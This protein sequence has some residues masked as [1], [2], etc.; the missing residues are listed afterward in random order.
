MELNASTGK[1]AI[2]PTNFDVKLGRG[3][4]KEAFL[5]HK[6]RLNA[7]IKSW[8]DRL[9]EVAEI[10][11]WNIQPNSE[12]IELALKVVLH[13]PRGN[14]RPL[15]GKLVSWEEAQTSGV[16][17]GSVGR[18]ITSWQKGKLL[19]NGSYGRVYEILTDDGT[20]FAV[21]EVYLLDQGCQSLLYL[22]QE[23]SLLSQLRH[24]N[25]VRYYGTEKDDEK[26][27]LFLEL[28]TKGSLAMLYGKYDLSD[29]QVSALSTLAFPSLP[30]I[31]DLLYSDH[32]PKWLS[33]ML[34]LVTFDTND[35]LPI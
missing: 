4:L 25:I 21:K 33:P 14:E 34:D 16:D 17:N 11:E 10:K 12:A 18:R 5:E 3:L 35:Y 28:M 30:S 19:G 2:L 26:I 20:F 7:D 15:D 29:S 13:K 6:R 8:K 22:E 23:I 24:D 1:P 27:Y 31:V 32:W 9:R